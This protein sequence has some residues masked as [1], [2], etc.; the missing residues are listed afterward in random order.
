MLP[1]MLSGWIVICWLT[2]IDMY[3]IVGDNNSFI[4]L[5]LCTH[6]EPNHDRVLFFAGKKVIGVRLCKNIERE[7]EGL[8]YILMD[9]FEED[10]K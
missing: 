3:W 6:V 8:K 5:D 4:N 1:V 2:F 10:G 7:I 9:Q